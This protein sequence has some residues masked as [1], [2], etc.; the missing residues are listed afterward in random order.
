[1][2]AGIN[3]LGQLAFTRQKQ[4]RSATVNQERVKAGNHIQSI[5]FKAGDDTRSD[6][7]T[8]HPVESLFQIVTILVLVPDDFSLAL[9]IP[10]KCFGLDRVQIANNQIRVQLCGPQQ[11]C[12]SVHSD[13]SEWHG[14]GKS[15]AHV[16]ARNHAVNA[17]EALGSGRVF[18]PV[19]DQ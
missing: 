4:T 15:V 10:I 7:V 14:K 9:R 12:A 5:T 3:A 17:L 18:D 8:P 1:M 19:Q 13:R 6:L 16:Q 11:V 2:K